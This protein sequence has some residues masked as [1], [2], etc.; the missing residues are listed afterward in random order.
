MRKKKKKRETKRVVTRPSVM[1]S[2]IVR[3]SVDTTVKSQS[4]NISGTKQERQA[5]R[6]NQLQGRG[7]NEERSS[8]RAAETTTA[9]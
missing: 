1:M 7:R 6:A 8:N 5:P 9:R 2:T 4:E 3:D